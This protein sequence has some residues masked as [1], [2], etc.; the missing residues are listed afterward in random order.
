MQNCG[1]SAKLRNED[2]GDMFHDSHRH[3]R[4]YDTLPTSKSRRRWPDNPNGRSKF[5]NLRL[6]MLARSQLTVRR[7]LR[8]WRWLPE[9]AQTARCRHQTRR[10][11]WPGNPNGRLKFHDLSLLTLARSQLTL[12]RRL[13]GWQ[14]FRRSFKQ[15]V[16][17]V[18]NFAGISS[19]M[20]EIN[21]SCAIT[22][23]Y[24]YEIKQNLSKNIFLL[25]RSRYYDGIAHRLFP[26]ITCH[27]FCSH[28]RIIISRRPWPS[29]K[30][31]DI[32]IEEFFL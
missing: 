16:G 1:F 25:L 14:R 21:R 17:D 26:T 18:E 15:H 6:F 22:K 4:W 19:S 28:L 13:R 31:L 23:I 7:R 12:Q 29:L 2:G 10:W 8:G 27:I 20:I 30:N 5:R 9:M 24:A 3:F 32:H 11:R